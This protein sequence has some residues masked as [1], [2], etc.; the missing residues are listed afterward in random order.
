MIR[1][2]SVRSR[3]AHSVRARF[4]CITWSLVIWM[5][6]CMSSCSRTF[7]REQADIDSYDAIAEKITDSRWA[8]PRMDITPDPRS[9][10]YSPFDPDAQPFPP[11]DPSAHA[12]MHCADGWKG[13]DG[14]HKFGDRIS[15]ENPQWL[16]SYGLTPDM[17]DPTTGAYVGQLPS[18]QNLKLRDLIELS[19]IHSRE[20]Q[21]Q[22]EDVYLAALA[23]TFERFQFGVR[24]LGLGGGEPGANLDYAVNPDGPADSLALGTTFGMS[25]LLPAGG[26]FIV[27]LMN[28]TLWL[29]GPDQVS[30]ASLL[31]FS[32]VQPLLAG[33]GRKVFLEGLTQT[34]RNLLY[35][36]RDLARF[37]KEFFTDVVGGSNG[38]L[39]LLQQLQQ[40]RNQQDN[41]RRLKRQIAELQAASTELPG[42]YRVSLDEWPEDIKIPPELELSM[43]YDPE[44]NELVWRGPMSQSEE[45][46]IKALAQDPR[47][48]LA[49]N[50]LIER[51]RV[52]PATLDE[53]NLQSNLAQSINTL[54]AQ[55]QSL[56]D[57]LDR[58]KLTLGLPT[59]IP[60]EIN[61]DWLKMFAFIDP[62]L[63]SVESNI[64]SFVSVWGKLDPLAPDP[65]SLQ[66][67]VEVYSQLVQ[68]TE[69]VALALVQQD[70]QAI[71]KKLESRLNQLTRQE[72]RD[73]VARDIA[74]DKRRFENASTALQEMKRKTEELLKKVRS[75]DGKDPE[76]QTAIR[77]VQ[78]RE[79][80]VEELPD[81]LRQQIETL[82]QYSSDVKTLQELLLRIVRG[83]SV[84][85]IGL[86]VELVDISPYER[87]MEQSVA[88]AI[89]N[90]LDLMN[91]RA[92]VADARRQV[93]IT[94]NRLNSTLDLVVEGDI[95]NRGRENPV[96]FRADL[97]QFRLGLRFT[98]PIDQIDER[99]DYRAA[100]I[101]YDRARRDYIAAEDLVKQQVRQSWRSLA[102][103]RRNLETSRQAIRIAALQLDSA[104]EEANAPQDPNQ[105]NTTGLGT[106]GRALLDALRNVLQA[107][108][109]LIRN[110]VNYEQSRLN[111]H[112][113]MGIM[114]VGAD[115]LWNDPFYRDEIDEP[116]DEPAPRLEKPQG[117]HTRLDSDYSVGRSR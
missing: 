20:Y 56:Q 34:E 27:E 117:D 97:S 100:L 71:D 61:D 46:Q 112:R 83:M 25:Q 9:R 28:N 40:V 33:A 24:Y 48:K 88:L 15:V 17:I 110:W 78:S 75:L 93:E 107:Q 50:E 36:L 44:E 106:R 68:Q 23:V 103:L 69:Q 26:Q 65:A 80:A 64:E 70:M 114:E 84:I 37:R 5:P 43:T 57:S 6:I 62:E 91:Q 49:L 31:S 99:N 18:L 11:D 101:A 66:N 98:A 96:D 76:L 10:F 45:Q 81:N 116:Q 86:R 87:S 77:Q 109:G 67:A 82:Q 47:L 89:E 58:F 16:A 3:R 59:D 94:A 7:W 35:E 53:L 2:H 41:I 32:L 90:R 42:V 60:L 54:R 104:V 55:Q 115:G 108:D 51:I 63:Q 38:Y 14:W 74:A 22:L 39:S 1:S 12:L 105:I 95:R 85:Q 113:D 13:Y 73:R 111:I 92:I 29:F 102:V 4:R 30:S 72:D 79:V 21:T 52:V 19:L 8:V